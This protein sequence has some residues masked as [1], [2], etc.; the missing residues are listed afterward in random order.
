MCPMKFHLCD[1]WCV[2]FCPERHL[3]ESELKGSD[4]T[5]STGMDV[6]LSLLILSLLRFLDSKF[7]GNS[8]MDLAINIKTMIE[9]K[10][11]RGTS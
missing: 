9:S 10:P 2:I 3:L 6:E 8:P 5:A 7:L 4:A 1:F 11:S